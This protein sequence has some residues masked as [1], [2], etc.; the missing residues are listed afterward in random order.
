MPRRRT[1]QWSLCLTL[2][3]CGSFASGVARAQARGRP[4]LEVDTEASRVVDARVA[5]RL[6]ALETADVEV[7][8]A[9]GVIVRA[10]L[11]FRVVGSN[12]GSLRVELW[13]LGRPY[14]AR[15]VSSTGTQGL[16]ARRIALAA[17]ELARQLRER[18]VL[19]ILSESRERARALAPSPEREGLPIYGRI[20]LAAGARFATLGVSDAWVIGPH[21]DGSL[22]FSSGPRL[23]L[24][25]AWLT[26]AW[27]APPSADGSATPRN[28]RWLEATL[29]LTQRVALGSHVELD[30]GLSAALASVR[31]ASA[32]ASGTAPLDTW[33]AR[34]GAIARLEAVLGKHLAL[35][36]G[37]D[38]GAVLRPLD[39]A[40]PRGSDRLG[41]LWLGGTL[42][43]VLDPK[44]R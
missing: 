42:T 29:A 36:L 18:R 19:E 15:Q 22:R 4:I 25:G 13:E 44:S 27:D 3:L 24:G 43:A 30:V 20:A 40:G 9:P 28:A 1:R 6:V 37:P 12:R 14:G 34:G 8:P 11:Y 7:P 31:V 33:S 10:P 35:A 16:E 23:T 26:G 17:A 2:A 21:L 38:V 41:G 32:S 5:E 39:L